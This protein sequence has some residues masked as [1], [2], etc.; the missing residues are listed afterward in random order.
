MEKDLPVLTGV[1]ALAES[2]VVAMRLRAISVS[3]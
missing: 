2:H 1:Q 3:G